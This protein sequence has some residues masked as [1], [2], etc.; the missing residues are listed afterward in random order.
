MKRPQV[1]RGR[2]AHREGSIEFC[3][4]TDDAVPVAE[5]AESFMAIDRA[6]ASLGTEDRLAVTELRSGSI[7]ATL[8]PFLP[9]M[10]EA[11]P[12]LS[13][14]NTVGNFSKRMKQA[15]D[16]FADLGSP[17]NVVLPKDPI[18]SE[19]AAVIKPLAGKKEATFQIARVKYR[20]ETSDRKV[21]VIAEY[22][23]EEINRAFVNA[24]KYKANAEQTQI[25]KPLEERNY[26]KG[27]ML[28]LHQANSGPA[29]RRGQTG[30]KGVIEAISDKV[31]PVYFADGIN[32]LKDQMVQGSK[33]PLRNAFIVDAWV[34]RDDG[35]VKDYTIT[36]VHDAK[37][38][39]ASRAAGR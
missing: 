17:K 11:L 34:H 29:K 16:G 27:V 19:I 38:L 5:L 21:E 7:I 32:D 14:A 9:M 22:G 31:L 2:E 10:G 15:L 18:A 37:L 13:A 30:D 39:P 33:N 35:V 25:E 8:A 1:K 20:S 6:F 28:V 23:A 3:F 4:G 24:Q 12:A 36:E 26:I